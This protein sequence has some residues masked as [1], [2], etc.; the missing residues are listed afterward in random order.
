[1][2]TKSKVKP[3]LS[4]K[5][6]LDNWKPKPSHI[7][8][9]RIKTPDGTILISRHRHDF[10]GYTDKVTGGYYA[11]DGGHEYTKRCFDGRY[12][13]L[14]VYDTDNFELIRNTMEWGT[15]GIK[16]DQPLQYRTL[17]HM[18]NSHIAAIV[19]TQLHIPE[20][21][22]KIF[23]KELTYRAKKNIDI[24]DRLHESEVKQKHAEVVKQN[25]KQ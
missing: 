6:L 12:E 19:K 2:T 17:C 11:V 18:S 23:K 20:W 1:M 5:E 16:G 25:M 21:A 14:T 13:E 3:K 4:E 8:S 9:N 24:E 10:V 7:V 22:K 15:Y